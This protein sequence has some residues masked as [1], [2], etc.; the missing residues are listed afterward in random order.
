MSTYMRQIGAG[1]E[2]R[3]LIFGENARRLLKLG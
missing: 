3:K 2:Q 1:S